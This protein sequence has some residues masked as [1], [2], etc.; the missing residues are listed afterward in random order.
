MFKK[1][2]VMALLVFSVLS[3]NVF[4]AE[5]QPFYAMYD[6]DPCCFM[7]FNFCSGCRG[8]VMVPVVNAQD[9][10]RQYLNNDGTVWRDGTKTPGVIAISAYGGC[11]PGWICPEPA[12]VT[13]ATMPAPVAQAQPGQFV[14]YFDFDKDQI[15]PEHIPALEEALAYALNTGAVSITVTSYTDFRGSTEYNDALGLRRAI[16]VEQWFLDATEGMEIVII[17]NGAQ[18]IIRPLDGKYCP[19]C[20]QDRRVDITTGDGNAVDTYIEPAGAPIN[21]ATNMGSELED[22][23]GVEEFDSIEEAEAARNK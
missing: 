17:N 12:M 19:D 1:I 9:T 18:E 22:T 23:E 2:L 20:W 6:K 15:V 16:A 21:G 14:V 3:A 11:P 5:C 10:G 7:T 13:D 4:A 8:F